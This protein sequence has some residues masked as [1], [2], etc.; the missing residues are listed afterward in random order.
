MRTTRTNRRLAAAVLTGLLGLGVGLAGT[1]D[2]DIDD[3]TACPGPDDE[4]QIVDCGG[5]DDL[6]DG[7][8]DVVNPTPDPDPDPDPEPEVDQDLPDAPVDDAVVADPTF[9]G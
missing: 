7:P 5:G 2:A 9:T 6:P 1:A 3:L 4:G 8:D